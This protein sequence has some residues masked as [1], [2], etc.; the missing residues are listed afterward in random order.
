MEFNEHV[1]FLRNG[2][3]LEFFFGENFIKINQN[4][5]FN[6]FIKS[7]KHALNYKSEEIFKFVQMGVVLIFLVK[8]YLRVNQLHMGFY[9]IFKLVIL[10][11]LT[12]NFQV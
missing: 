7:R 4:Q 5:N 9:E 12:E 8:V 2:K 1:D 6:N 11:S 3:F 10:H